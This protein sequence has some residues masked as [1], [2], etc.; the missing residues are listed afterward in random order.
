MTARRHHFVSQCYLKRF[1]VPRN[2]KKLQ[3][4]VFDRHEGRSYVCSTDDI[5]LER[6]FNRIE[7]DGVAPDAVEA[8]L[9]DFESEADLALDRTNSAG[10]WQSDED[11]ECVLYLVALFAIRNPRARDLMGNFHER[12]FKQMMTA[13]LATNER[14]DRL[15]KNARDAGY[16][17]PEANVTYEEV[18]EAL[19]S[20]KY[21]I[22]LSNN[23]HLRTGFR[24]VEKVLP[25]LRMRRWVFLRAPPDSGGFV[26]SDHPVNLVWSDTARGNLRP[27]FGRKHT[28]VIFPLSTKLAVVGAFELEDG[29]RV[30]SDQMV[31]DINGTTIHFATRQVYARD[32]HFRYRLSDDNGTRKAS[33][34]I[35]D[36][37]F[38][39]R[40][41]TTENPT[42]TAWPDEPV[43][44]NFVSPEPETRA[45]TEPPAKRAAGEPEREG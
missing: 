8:A 9:A 27:G 2:K 21:R 13:S 41:E 10:T 7:A 12:L 17:P 39:R 32:L 24:L 31:E 25:F 37:G 18:K 15:E 38:R 33:R 3:L 14:W 23:E 19:S 26:T 43:E 6:D 40:K 45:A 44:E 5:G 16:I 11:R 20:E 36:H 35:D 4:H 29:T 30:V 34:L 42:E 1:A 22:E 28:E